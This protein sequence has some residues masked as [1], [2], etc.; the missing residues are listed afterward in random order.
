MRVAGVEVVLALLV[1]DEPAVAAALG[2][3]LARDEPA[4]D[5]APAAADALARLARSS[6]DLIVAATPAC[7]GAPAGRVAPRAG[8]SW[9]IVGRMTALV[10]VLLL[11][12]FLGVRHATDPDHVIAVTTIVCRQRSLRGAV[13][14]GG[15]WGIGH[16]VT[17]LVVGIAI[18]G[19]GVVIPPR[20]GLGME[21][22]VAVMLVLLGVLTL[23]GVTR[24]LQEGLAGDHHRAGTPAAHAHPHAHGDYVHSHLHGH[25]PGAHG[26]PEERTPQARIDR[27]LGRF[28]AYQAVRPVVVGLVHGLAGSAA[29]ALLVLA[30]IRDPWWAMAYLLVFGLGTIAG[31]VL[32]TA[33]IGV[34]FALTAGRFARI[35]RH[36]A[37][38]SGLLSLGFGLWLAYQLGV[39]DGLFTADPRWFPR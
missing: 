6:P 37:M 5:W 1:D 21:F 24:R 39:V 14:V 20:L 15:L 33:A 22:S 17:I 23:T 11:G 9:G 3:I 35:N 26:H 31:M 34:P 2:D 16:T 19:F 28:P 29:I 18:V 10:S 32:I 8:G 12:F 38:A 30:A 36:L 4:V 27:A 13:W 25:A 7:P